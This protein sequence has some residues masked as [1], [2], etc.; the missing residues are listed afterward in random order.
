MNAF[1]AAGGALL[2]L[3]HVT[4]VTEQG[5]GIRILLRG[6]IAFIDLDLSVEEFTEIL[7]DGMEA[8]Q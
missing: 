8:A 5:T 1:I 2:N 7:L 3:S 6:K 4:A